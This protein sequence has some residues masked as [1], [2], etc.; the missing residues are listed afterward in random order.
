MNVEEDYALLADPSAPQQVDSTKKRRIKNIVIQAVWVLWW[1]IIFGLSIVVVVG[2]FVQRRFIPRDHDKSNNDLV[3]KYYRY[4]I[5]VYHPVSRK[6]ESYQVTDPYSLS[7]AMNSEF[8]QVV[9]LDVTQCLGALLQGGDRQGNGC[10]ADLAAEAAN[11]KPVKKPTR[12]R[13]T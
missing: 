3:G 7:L 10:G 2:S 4:D 8:S 6:L 11:P 13:K 5:Q 12:P 1:L 9:D